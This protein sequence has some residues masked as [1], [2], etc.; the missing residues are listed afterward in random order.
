MGLIKVSGIVM[1]L[2]TK[3]VCQQN[4]LELCRISEYP[5]CGSRVDTREQTDRHMDQTYL[6][7]SIAKEKG[8]V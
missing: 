6:E 8:T 3:S 2:Q 7:L 1:S 5:F 4:L